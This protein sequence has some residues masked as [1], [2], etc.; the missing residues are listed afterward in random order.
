MNDSKKVLVASKQD[1]ILAYLW[2]EFISDIHNIMFLVFRTNVIYIKESLA[3]GFDN[4]F[5]LH[6]IIKPYIYLWHAVNKLYMHVSLFLYY[7]VAITYILL[8]DSVVTTFLR[9]K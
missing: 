4:P 3:H 6:T 9:S 8:I 7:T 5:Y 1:Q 2:Y